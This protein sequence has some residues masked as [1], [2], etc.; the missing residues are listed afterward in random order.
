MVALN[1][2]FTPTAKGTLSEDTIRLFLRQLAGA[3]KAL[4]AKG[5]V[6]RD[7]KP[8]NILL[9]HSITGTKSCPQPNEIRLKIG[10]SNMR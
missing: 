8:Q 3:M 7:L 6:H 4:H 1:V 9:S 5:I 2:K 10:E